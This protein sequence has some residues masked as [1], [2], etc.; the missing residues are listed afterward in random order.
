MSSLLGASSL[1]GRIRGSR[2][3][4]STLHSAKHHCGWLKLGFYLI[5]LQLA[6]AVQPPPGCSDKS[7]AELAAPAH[8]DV[9]PPVHAVCHLTRRGSSSETF[10]HK[11]SYFLSWGKLKETEEIRWKKLQKRPWH[12]PSRGC[13][14]D[15]VV[16]FSYV[17]FLEKRHEMSH[18]IL[19][20]LYIREVYIILLFVPL[21]SLAESLLM[22]FSQL[23]GSSQFCPESF[24]CK[25]FFCARLDGYAGGGSTALSACLADSWIPLCWQIC[26]LSFSC[27]SSWPPPLHSVVSGCSCPSV[28]ALRMHDVVLKQMLHLTKPDI[29][30]VFLW[31]GNQGPALSLC[32]G[33]LLRS[34]I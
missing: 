32:V 30:S 29:S 17:L 22:S 34:C 2:N 16:D 19:K 9:H 28:R 5:C 25:H 12:L 33:Y 20:Y 13:P 23:Q 3:K 31:R 1:S 21:S 8:D 4:S 10:D 18:P 15:T 11:Y 6:C 27:F 24:L 26:L 14:C 7:P